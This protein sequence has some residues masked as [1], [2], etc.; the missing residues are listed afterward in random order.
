MKLIIEKYKAPVTIFIFLF[1]LFSLVEFLFRVLFYDEVSYWKTVIF[2]AIAS[3]L[4]SYMLLKT[5]DVKHVKDV[6]KYKRKVI[7]VSEKLHGKNVYLLMGTLKLNGYIINSK[8][9]NPD[10]IHLK[11]KSNLL[12]F[13]DIYTIRF[14]ANSI[15]IKSRPRVAVNITDAN[16]ITS[17]RVKQIEKI[18]NMHCASIRI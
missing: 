13:G 1:V 9:S 8:K 2:G 18:V 7:S 10:I 16:R 3:V 11:S 15:V 6:I 17:N 4:V 12:D 14:L 5:G